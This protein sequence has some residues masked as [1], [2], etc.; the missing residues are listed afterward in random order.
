MMWLMGRAV[1]QTPPSTTT[2]PCPSTNP[3]A[4]L[5]FSVERVVDPTQV[6]STVTP[7]IPASVA[8]GVQNKVLEIHETITFN[9]PVLTLNL[10]PM[11]AGSPIPT[12]PHGVIPGTVF[13][14]MAVNVDKVYT[15][16][17]P[18][19]SVMFV[20]TVAADAT[21]YPFGNRT[22]A[23][24]AVFVGLTND[25]PPLIKNV[26]ELEAGIA[27]SYSPTGAGSILFLSAPVVPPGTNNGPGIVVN[28][29]QLT[30]LPVVT[31]DASATTSA[32]PPLTFH[33]T[34][35][36]GAADIANASSAKATGYI[37]GSAGSYT[38]RVMV[39]D[40]KGNVMTKDVT[41]QYLPT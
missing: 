10:F 26:V 34:V 37:L 31:L 16:C 30:T 15:T 27:V 35:V 36:A 7:L 4:L 12:P 24:A 5:F 14:T 22:G 41:I 25:N 23:P 29:P 13:S 40:S 32:N 17:T 20:G 33:W 18:N 11:Q 39:T 19:T 1:A 28:V 3:P 9:N 6:L 38:F 21:V 8:T 2:N